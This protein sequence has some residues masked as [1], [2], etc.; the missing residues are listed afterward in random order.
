MLPGPWSGPGEGLVGTW[1]EPV[2][3]GGGWPS[4][5][6]CPPGGPPG[7]LALIT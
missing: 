3:L 1:L 2:L 7:Q 4:P 5:L 6:A